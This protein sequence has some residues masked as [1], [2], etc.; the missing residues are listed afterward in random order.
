[1]NN[2]YTRQEAA[3]I[4]RMSVWTL[5]AERHCGRLAFIQR[6]ANGKVLITEEA[7]NEY[8]AKANH[9]IKPEIRTVRDTYRKK[10]A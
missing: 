9:P 2:L 8:L 1:M 7:I 5:D 10:R 3:E 4:L 6:K